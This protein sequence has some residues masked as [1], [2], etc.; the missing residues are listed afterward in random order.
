MG[1]GAGMQYWHELSKEEQAGLRGV[2]A[3]QRPHVRWKEIGAAFNVW[4]RSLMYALET[5]DQIKER[6]SGDGSTV[7]TKRVG[8]RAAAEALF[9][10]IPTDTRSLTAQLLGDP[11]PGRSAL[12]QERAHG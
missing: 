9:G 2:V 10:Q 3:G 8:L 12:D 5:K 11:L 1:S 6:H 7:K 4:P